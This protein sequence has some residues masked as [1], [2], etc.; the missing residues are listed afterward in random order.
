[1]EYH[2]DGV[3]DCENNFDELNCSMLLM[4]QN[5]YRK[6]YPPLQMN[7]K[8]TIIKISVLIISLGNFEEI[9]MRFTIKF[10]VLLEW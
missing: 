8:G 6:E 1:M 4:D 3:A 2:C 9:D 10:L 5:L 7:R